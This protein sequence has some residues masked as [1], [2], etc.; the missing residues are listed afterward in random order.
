MLTTEIS[1][2]RWKLGRQADN[3]RKVFMESAEGLADMAR[4]ADEL[5][6]ARR[7]IQELGETV[8]DAD[9]EK[10]V[11]EG[12][13][14]NKTAQRII[15]SEAPEALRK[16]VNQA[17]R[18]V[19][20]DVDKAAKGTISRIIKAS[21]DELAAL[22]TQTGRS[23][24]DLK[25]FRDQIHDIARRNNVDP[26]TLRISTDD[27][28]ANPGSKVGRDRDVTFFV[29]DATGKHLSDV[30][31]DISKNIYE[32]ELWR[33]TRPGEIPGP[34]DVA[35]HAE[36][37]D[38]MVTSRW[39]PEAYN[40]GDSSFGDFLNT[41]RPPTASRV[42]DIID[43]M[44][45][46]SQHWWNMAA[47]E[48]DPILRSQKI[49]EG[50]RQATKQWDRIIE[51]R[52]GRYLGDATT[53]SRLRIPPDLEVGLEIFRKVEQGHVTPRQA[54]EMLNRL[55]L[56]KESVLTK[57]TGFFEAVEKDVGR[58][59]RRVGAA[60]LDDILKRNPFTPGTTEWGSEALG[61]ING[62]L[63][64]GKI[65]G[66]VFMARRTGVLSQIQANVEAVAADAGADAFRAFESWV[67]RAL[68]SRKISRLE[69]R[70][71]REWA[72]EQGH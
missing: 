46:K 33:R 50:M 27:F 37:L 9:F 72:A 49:A 61:Q 29:D 69:A 35:R 21:D 6:E 7:V 42:E 14:T 16:R 45:V 52:V 64:S 38:Q 3:A 24:D 32:D 54:Q 68:A 48:A 31:H 8:S 40:S 25:R 26:S 58:Q 39:H 43:T 4:H 18:G 1:Y 41:G 66:D 20:D 56:T 36:D 13:Q 62:A 63:K 17:L 55:G 19:Y 2:N 44:N 23:V 71:M 34:G 30:H 12:F 5:A 57:M 15:N 22:A 59:F 51:P 10:M 11:L 47:N 60:Q 65:S 53:A 67:G 28:S 70:A